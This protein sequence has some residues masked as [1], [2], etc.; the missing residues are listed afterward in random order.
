MVFITGLA[1][2]VYWLLISVFSVVTDKAALITAL[3]FLIAGLLVEGYPHLR[4]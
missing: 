1:F 4:K 2:F 3:V